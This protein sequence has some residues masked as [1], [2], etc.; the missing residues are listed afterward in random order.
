MSDEQPG[1]STTTAGSPTEL[2]ESLIAQ[3]W[4]EVLGIESPGRSDDFFELGGDSL[5]GLELTDK[6]GQR[7][8]FEVPLVALFFQDP[9]IRGFA[10]AI[11]AEAS[12]EDLARLGAGPAAAS[13]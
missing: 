10:G 2:L 12:A 6:V 5:Q 7:L 13:A 11:V 4:T 9:T 3:C 8:P 1:S